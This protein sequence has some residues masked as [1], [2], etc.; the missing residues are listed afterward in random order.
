MITDED[1]RIPE[2]VERKGKEKGWDNYFLSPRVAGDS[3]IHWTIPDKE[4]C[5]RGKGEGE[6]G[7]TAT[8]SHP[9]VA[10][11]LKFDSQL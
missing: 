10:G 6:R 5:S 3:K 4:K 9:K 1:Q 7:G 2:I 11:K 8:F